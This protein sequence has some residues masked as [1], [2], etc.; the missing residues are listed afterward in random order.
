MRMMNSNRKLLEILEKHGHMFAP[1]EPRQRLKYV[2]PGWLAVLAQALGEIKASGRSVLIERVQAKGGALR[3]TFRPGGDAVAENH[4]Q[5]LLAECR[6]YCP[7][8]GNLWPEN[9]Q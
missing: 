7:C 5:R 1:D 3:A 8:C 9:G 6:A 2:P 4:L